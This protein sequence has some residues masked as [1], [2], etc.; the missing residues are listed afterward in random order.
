MFAG[1]DEAERRGEFVDISVSVLEAMLCDLR[2]GPDLEDKF[3][4]LEEMYSEDRKF[5][6]DR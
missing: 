3:A 5:Q 4:H 1:M 2:V 6:T